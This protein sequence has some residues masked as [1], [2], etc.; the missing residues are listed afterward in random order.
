LAALRPEPGSRTARSLL[1]VRSGIEKLL[2]RG[3]A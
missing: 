2:K 3:L 1:A